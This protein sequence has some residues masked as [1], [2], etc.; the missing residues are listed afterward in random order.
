MCAALRTKNNDQRKKASSRILKSH[1]S[2]RVSTERQLARMRAIGKDG[3]IQRTV[4]RKR[5]V[6]ETAHYLADLARCV[7]ECKRVDEASRFARWLIFSGILDLCREDTSAAMHADRLAREASDLQMECGELFRG[8]K[9]D[10]KYAESDI[11]EINRKMDAMA[12]ILAATLPNKNPS[13]QTA[14]HR[15][16]RPIVCEAGTGRVLQLNPATGEP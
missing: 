2:Y 3:A 14:S 4:T 5:V 8:G 16:R 15:G 9:A 12:S 6:D 13:Q 11:A 1:E 7:R 10:P